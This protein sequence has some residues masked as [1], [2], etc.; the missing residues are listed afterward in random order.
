MLCT[1]LAH[2]LG[3]F[4]CI[5]L[6][7]MSC[8]CCILP[9]NHR[10]CLHSYMHAWLQCWSWWYMC[11]GKIYNVIRYRVSWLSL[12]IK[13]S[14]VYHGDDRTLGLAGCM[15]KQ[16]TINE[17]SCSQKDNEVS[18]VIQLYSMQFKSINFYLLM[19]LFLLFLLHILS[20]WTKFPSV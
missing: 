17:W 4:P 3:P 16:L 1:V 19:S 8:K 18:M 14:P 10:C 11:L 2:S 12:N 5:Q 13:A 7:T 15:L 9:C 20:K 6:F